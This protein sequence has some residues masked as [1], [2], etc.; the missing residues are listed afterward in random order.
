MNLINKTKLRWDL[1]LTTELDRITYKAQLTYTKEKDKKKLETLNNSVANLQ[2]IIS[3]DCEVDDKEIL[4]SFKSVIRQC[5][6]LQKRAKPVKIK[7]GFVKASRLGLETLTFALG[8]GSL[9]GAIG[10][11]VWAVIHGG[12]AVL[13]MGLGLLMPG[14]FDIAILL[15][16]DNAVNT[17]EEYEGKMCDYSLKNE[18]YAHVSELSKEFENQQNPELLLTT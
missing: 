10:F 16:L 11:L 6:L 9:G 5:K 4:N 13:V 18:E 7:K 3:T 1:Q 12:W 17:L 2:E 14:F 8:L 15:A